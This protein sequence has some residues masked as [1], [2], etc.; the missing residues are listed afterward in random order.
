MAAK[1]SAAAPWPLF[2][3]G[4]AHLTAETAGALTGQAT[5]DRSGRYRYLLTRDWDPSLPRVAFVMLN[6]NRAD[7][8]HDDPTI[9]R[10]TAFARA[11]GFGALDVVNLFALRAP[12]PALLLA[13]ADPVGTANDRVLRRIVRVAA[14]TVAAWG[15]HGTRYGRAEEVLTLLRRHAAAVACL[16]ITARGCPRHPLYVPA[17]T[18]LQPYAPALPDAT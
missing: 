5:F 11:W 18:P 9:R 13:A 12:K 1:A 8:R 15:N 7:A 3:S 6:P 2:P 17:A 16:G 14:L 10:C 4:N